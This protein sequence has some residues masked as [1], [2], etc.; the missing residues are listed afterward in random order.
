MRQ[1]PVLPKL[2]MLG[3]SEMERI[4]EFRKVTECLGSIEQA[5]PYEEGGED[6]GMAATRP[7]IGFGILRHDFCWRIALGDPL[8]E[9]MKTPIEKHK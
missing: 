6:Y 8:F 9:D 1:D 7:H 3:C 4:A 5:L 2:A